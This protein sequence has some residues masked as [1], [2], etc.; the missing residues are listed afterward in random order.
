MIGII[1]MLIT[2]PHKGWIWYKEDTSKIDTVK[3]D[4]LVQA[5]GSM[6][7]TVLTVYDS[8]P[9]EPDTPEPIKRLILKPTLDNAERYLTWYLKLSERATKLAY[10]IKAAAIKLG[11]ESAENLVTSQEARRTKYAKEDSVILKVRNRGF[12]LLYLSNDA[13]SHLL[14]GK[15]KEFA[16]KYKFLVFAITKG[17]VTV[18]P[19][20]I[21]KKDE[22]ELKTLGIKYPPALLLVYP[23]DNKAFVLSRFMI[24]EKELKKRIYLAGVGLWPAL[25]LY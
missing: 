23:D 9:I 19:P 13:M 25:V 3:R 15:T 10:A 24:S 8:L 17:N 22:G 4:V 2:F 11:L 21:K 18:P 6:P 7:D 16:D 14:M 20:V 12:L 5:T 1:I